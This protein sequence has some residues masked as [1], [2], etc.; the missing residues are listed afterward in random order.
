[1]FKK[2]PVSLDIYN[3]K[4]ILQG[5]NDFSD[6]CSI[7]FDGEVLTL[8]GDDEEQINEFFGEFMNYIL[9]L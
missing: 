9:T 2:Y 6:I 8:W 3:Q 4:N 5:I 7:S 1:M